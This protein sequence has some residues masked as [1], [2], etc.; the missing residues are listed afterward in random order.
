MAE[1]IP[2]VIIG[3]QVQQLPSGDTIAGGGGTSLPAFYAPILDSAFNFV[4][5]SAGELVL[6]YGG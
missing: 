4:F 6:G 2:L 1:Q 5:D 3:G